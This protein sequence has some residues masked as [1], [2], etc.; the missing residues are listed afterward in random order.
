MG[1][2][3][4]EK[5][6]RNFHYDWTSGTL[7]R[8]YLSSKSVHGVLEDM[9]VPDALEMVLDGRDNHRK[10]S[11]KFSLRLNIRNPVKT[12]PVLQVCSWRYGGHGGSWCTWKWFQMGDTII[13]KLPWNFN[14]DVKSWTTTY[15]LLILLVTKMDDR[16]WF[17]GAK[18]F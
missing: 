3:I 9:E 11:L 2:T 13:V 18:F 5:L 16:I 6:P 15:H 4:I 12:P 10:A 1:A 14:Q 7:S 8:L 17:C